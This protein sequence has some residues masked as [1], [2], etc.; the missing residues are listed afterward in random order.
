MADTST[1]NLSQNSTFD[2]RELYKS[3]RFQQGKPVL[4]TELNDA[5]D[6]TIEELLSKARLD[7]RFSGIETSPFEWAVMPTNVNPLDQENNDNFSVTIGRLPTRAG[8]LD[9]ENLFTANDGDFTIPY[10]P[11]LF[12]Q[13]GGLETVDNANYVFKG[14]VSVVDQVNNT[15]IFQDLSKNLQSHHLLTEQSTTYSFG[16]APNTKSLTVKT[17]ACRV[18]FTSALNPANVGDAYEIVN[19]GGNQ[20]EVN[21]LPASI[22]VGDQYVILPPNMLTANRSA[23]DTAVNSE[24][25]IGKEANPLQLIFVNTWEEDISSDEDPNIENG[26]IGT[27]TTHRTQLRWTVRIA[28]VFGDAIY[29]LAASLSDSGEHATADDAR[30]LLENLITTQ[31]FSIGS[32]RDSE[33]N[34]GANGFTQQTLLLSTGDLDLDTSE[35]NALSDRPQSILGVQKVSSPVLRKMG[36]DGLLNFDILK[37]VLGLHTTQ[38]SSVAYDRYSSDQLI[39]LVS[40]APSKRLHQEF[41]IGGARATDLPNFADGAAPAANSDTLS[42]RFW[43]NLDDIHNGVLNVADNAD[44]TIPRFW[45]KS[46]LTANSNGYYTHVTG[47]D[48][49][50]VQPSVYVAPPRIFLKSSDA[51][52]EIMRARQAFYGATPYRAMD[53]LRSVYA[54]LVLDRLSIAEGETLRQVL[55]NSLDGR[56]DA[57]DNAILS[58]IGQ[59]GI[60]QLRATGNNPA[61]QVGTIFRVTPC[62]NLLLQDTNAIGNASSGTTYRQQDSASTSTS[63]IHPTMYGDD[64]RTFGTIDFEDPLYSANAG[65]NAQVRGSELTG[66]AQLSQQNSSYRIRE[67][68]NGSNTISYNDEDLGW[69]RSKSANEQR[70]W[71]EG[72]AQAKAFKDSFNLRKLAIKTSAH[73]EADLFTIDQPLWF[74]AFSDNA[75]TLAF[76]RSTTVEPAGG[77]SHFA[78]ALYTAFDNLKFGATSVL[79]SSRSAIRS[80]R[81]DVHVKGPMGISS[82]AGTS[83]SPPITEN[84]IPISF[85]CS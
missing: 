43:P 44:A 80:Q 20:I 17:G 2:R 63:Y 52:A 39:L 69:S 71:H 58:I 74:Q 75:T 8:I 57:Y 76:L 64:V 13:V 85:T 6:M 23:W 79:A 25:I 53:Q 61:T 50:S 49:F 9:T 29:G 10:D 46:S 22:S 45:N 51:T 24:T 78:E 59:A 83:Y 38:G 1:P 11:F 28:N 12:K 19:A 18:V 4:D 31:E 54:P 3:V 72:I 60:T 15:S 56:L 7:Q 27:E 62:T 68:L 73:A 21:A 47:S 40:S 70:L 33:W 26:N 34:I 32:N 55:F 30:A 16:Q 36:D 5:Q 37:A 67:Q 35:D 41:L 42:A 84:F 14:K 77:P 48:L 66:K 65:W 81:A 82:A